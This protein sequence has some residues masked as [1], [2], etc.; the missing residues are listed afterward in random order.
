MRINELIDLQI[1]FPFQVFSQANKQKFLP[2]TSFPIYFLT[3]WKTNYEATST[4]LRDG[5]IHWGTLYP[6]RSGWRDTSDLETGYKLGREYEKSSKVSRFLPGHFGG[7]KCHLMWERTVVWRL[8][9]LVVPV[10][11]L[12][13]AVKWVVWHYGQS[14]GRVRQ[15]TDWRL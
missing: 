2:I 1:L 11:S 6:S 9:Q 8:V 10:G 4:I 3:Q 15:E 14:F 7:W 12:S 13:R 5:G